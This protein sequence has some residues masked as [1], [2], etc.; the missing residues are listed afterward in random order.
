MQRRREGRGRECAGDVDGAVERFGRLDAAL[1]VAG[2]AA[3][4]RFED[5]PP[6]VFNGVL[7]TNVG[8]ALNIARATLPVFRQQQAV[9]CSSSARCSAKSTCRS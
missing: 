7:D 5:I 9:T 6:D 3:Y 4:G 2:V 1:H 8:G